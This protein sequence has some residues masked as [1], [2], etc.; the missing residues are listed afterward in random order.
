MGLVFGSGGG[1]AS[2]G[3]ATQRMP[4][5]GDHIE[6]CVRCS[7]VITAADRVIMMHGDLFHGTCWALLSSEVR[8]ADSRQLAKLSTELIKRRRQKLRAKPTS[9]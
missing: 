4:V 6:Q 3:M 8:R 2:T 9:D 5:A 7:G 1:L